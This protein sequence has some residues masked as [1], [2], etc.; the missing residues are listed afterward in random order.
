ML[1]DS[2]MALPRQLSPLEKLCD[3][4]AIHRFA[5]LSDDFNPIHVDREFA[6]ASPMGGLIA[7][8]PLS[9]GLVFQVLGNA[10]NERQRS[11]ISVD[12]YFRRPVRENDTITAGGQLREDKTHTYAVWVRNQKGEI[13]AEGE[14]RVV[15]AAATGSPA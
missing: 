6:A 8:G 4:A 15:S 13:V 12:L 11:G 7:H 14:A 2:A 9:L 3:Y 1:N 10:L 5:V